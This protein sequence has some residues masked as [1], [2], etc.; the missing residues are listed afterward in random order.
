MT[1]CA[2]SLFR[3]LR[4]HLIRDERGVTMILFAFMIVGLLT[5]VAIVIDLG[6]ARQERR[7]LQNAADAAALAG[8]SVIDNATATCSGGDQVREAAKYTYNNMSIGT[9]PSCPTSAQQ[10]TI[11]NTQVTITTPY[12]G[13]PAVFDSRSKVNVKVC[14]D[15]STTFARV[16]DITSIHVCGNAT[17]RKAGVG[18]VGPPGTGTDPSDPDNPCTLDTFIP[19][20]YQPGGDAGGTVKEGTTVAAWFGVTPVSDPATLDQAIKPPTLIFNGVAQALTI[21]PKANTNVSGVT[22]HNVYEL[23]WKIPSGLANNAKYIIQLSAYSTDQL[24]HPP[25]GACGKTQWSFIKGKLASGGT[26]PCEPGLSGVVEDSFL[27]SIFPAPGQVVH[28]GDSVGATFQDE[29]PVYN[30]TTAGDPHMIVFQIDGADIPQAA[31]GTTVAQGPNTSALP[32]ST[33]TEYTLRSPTQLITTGEKYST[34]I[35]YKLPTTLSPGAHTVTLQAYDTDSNKAG[36]DCG[37]ATWTIN[38]AGSN[39]ELVQ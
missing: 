4:R 11:G 8:A 10:Y 31:A 27:G 2:V 32:G 17:A 22:Y 28:K 12:S 3:S 15:V 14:R 5:I 30:G 33:T 20:K 1:R 21:T 39:V 6:N 38:L 26:S 16:I 37:R 36:G 9:A 24:S 18:S 35:Q 23:K 7:G 25:N 13:G 29:S 34:D 19:G